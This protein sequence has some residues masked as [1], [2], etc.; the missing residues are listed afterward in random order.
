MGIDFSDVNRDGNIDFFVVEMLSTNHKRRKT[1]MGPMSFTPVSIGEVD[2]RPQYM[3]NTLLLNRG[4]NTFAEIAQLG[5][6]HASEWSWSPLFLDLDFDGYEDI[7]VVTGHYY[8]A[9]DADVQQELKTM[10][11][12]RYNQ[13]QSEVFAYSRLATKDFIF[14]YMI[15][16]N[17]ETIFM[18]HQISIFSNIFSITGYYNSN[19][20]N[21]L[22]Y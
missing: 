5:G 16:M 22:T 21:L 14:R 10:N 11:D 15:I 19:S 4:D 17:N 6:V 1:Q 9:M 20:R 8:D 13:L 18:N 2:N 12:T 3:R 7:L